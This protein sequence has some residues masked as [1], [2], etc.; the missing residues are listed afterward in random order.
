VSC[1]R[2]TSRFGQTKEA[3]EDLGEGEAEV[4]DEPLDREVL[5]SSRER[6]L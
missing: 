6:R 4:R 2:P 5:R 1:R 3:A